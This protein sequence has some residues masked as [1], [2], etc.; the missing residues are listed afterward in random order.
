MLSLEVQTKETSENVMKKFKD[1][2]GEG[3]LGLELT[4]DTAGC[5][6]F[7]GGGGF[8]TASVCSEESGT[9]IQLETREWDHQVKRFA[10]EIG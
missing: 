1:Y 3:G 5:L 4:S 6:T 8:V 9:K 10:S 7:E 2:F